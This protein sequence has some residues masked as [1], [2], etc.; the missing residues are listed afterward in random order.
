MVVTG[1]TVFC[2]FLTLRA[3]IGPILWP[4]YYMSRSTFD[5]IWL[6]AILFPVRLR[7]P[8]GVRGYWN[9]AVQKVGKHKNIDHRVAFNKT[10]YHA[11]HENLAEGIW[12]KKNTLLYKLYCIKFILLQWWNYCGTLHM[13]Q[14]LCI[15]ATG[16]SYNF[17]FGICICCGKW[18]LWVLL[19]PCPYP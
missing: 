14:R 10:V 6:V 2:H 19:W 1:C 8:M 11:L 13:C 12:I 17:S 7:M 5:I 3:P 4:V 16:E 15:C 9:W 18:H